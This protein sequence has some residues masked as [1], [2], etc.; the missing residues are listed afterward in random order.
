MIEKQVYD[1]SFE[2]ARIDLIKPEEQDQKKVTQVIMNQLAGKVTG[3]DKK[4]LID[5]ISNLYSR[6]TEAVLIACT[7]LPLVINQEDVTI[8][9]IDCTQVYAN[10]AARLS[11]NTKLFKQMFTNMNR[12]LE[13]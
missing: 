2:K 1:G 10:E 7:D 8:P 4:S 3:E 13:K 12:C 6:G 11:Q 9:V 5:V